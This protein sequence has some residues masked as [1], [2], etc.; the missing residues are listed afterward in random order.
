M[1]RI[2]TYARLFACGVVCTSHDTEGG[3]NFD[4]QQA[5]FR[6]VGDTKPGS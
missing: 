3:Y 2:V 1:H 5:S 4:K 6:H